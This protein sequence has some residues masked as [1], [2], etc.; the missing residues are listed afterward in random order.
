MV[1]RGIMNLLI[2][3]CVSMPLH[4]SSTSDYLDEKYNDLFVLHLLGG[5]RK[6]LQE[7]VATGLIF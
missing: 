5:R 2:C 1:A 7:L 4:T 3:S 6:N